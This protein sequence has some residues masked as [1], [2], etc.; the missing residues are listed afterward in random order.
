METNSTQ[1]LAIL[2]FL[3]AFTFLAAA[4][5]TGGNLVFILLFLVGTAFSVVLFQKGKPSKY[6][7]DQT[8]GPPEKL[9]S[10]RIGITK[11]AVGGGG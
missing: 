1:G 10:P 3:V 11:K 4:L 7:E 2:M 9:G 6:T 8:V 5:F